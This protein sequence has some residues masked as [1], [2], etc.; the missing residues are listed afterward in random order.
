MIKKTVDKCQR[1]LNYSGIGRNA[2]FG[3]IFLRKGLNR[4]LNALRFRV[5]PADFAREIASSTNS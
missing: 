3:L 5:N 4:A 1:F 2:I